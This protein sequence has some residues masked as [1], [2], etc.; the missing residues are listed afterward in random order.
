[1]IKRQFK[2]LVRNTYKL[3]S[4]LLGVYCLPAEIK[5]YFKISVDDGSCLSRG[6]IIIC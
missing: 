1:M 6:I 3:F 5:M 2:N 4:F